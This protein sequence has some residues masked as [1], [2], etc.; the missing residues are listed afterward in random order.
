M[1]VNREEIQKMFDEH[2]IDECDEVFDASEEII[3]FAIKVVKNCSIPLV[4]ESKLTMHQL[5]CDKWELRYGETGDVL[6]DGTKEECDDFAK[7]WL[8]AE[9]SGI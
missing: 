9:S 8:E 3:D 2:F 7:G 6:T 1:D 5:S 4:S